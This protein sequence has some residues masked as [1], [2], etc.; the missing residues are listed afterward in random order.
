MSKL[1]KH[2]DSKIV[3]PKHSQ[4]ELV[5]AFKGEVSRLVTHHLKYMAKSLKDIDK[6]M[7][8]FFRENNYESVGA[9]D[10]ISKKFEE[11]LRLVIEGWVTTDDVLRARFKKVFAAYN[12]KLKTTTMMKAINEQL[13]ALDSEIGEHV[14]KANFYGDKWTKQMDEAGLVVKDKVI[15][16]TIKWFKNLTIED[17]RK[18]YRDI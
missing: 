6:Q 7:Q 3:N 13:E 1:K 8:S 12:A 14:T 15:K 10:A 11:Q 16:N 17:I 9:Q 4:A 18:S 2:L 5:E